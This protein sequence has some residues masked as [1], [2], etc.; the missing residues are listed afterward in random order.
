[1]KPS[2]EPEER[3][4]FTPEPEIDFE[5]IGVYINFLDRSLGILSSGGLVPRRGDGFSFEAI[6]IENITEFGSDLQ[7]LRIRE[8]C[9]REERAL[10]CLMDGNEVFI[11]DDT[12]RL[13]V[14]SKNIP[15]TLKEY[16]ESQGGPE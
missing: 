1:V 7:P 8:R 10:M 3:P 9:P 5:T 11:S 4:G 16:V 6:S 15:T 2:N 12:G 13:C 14:R